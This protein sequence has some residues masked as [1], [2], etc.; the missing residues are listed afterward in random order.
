LEI[1]PGFVTL[2]STHTNEVIVE[3]L[4][5]IE[6]SGGDIASLAENA[7]KVLRCCLKS[8]HH[9]TECYFYS[10]NYLTLQQLLLAFLLIMG[11]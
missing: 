2:G 11:I 10:I 5:F 8:I 6:F 3:R 4:G 9:L 1:E 7:N